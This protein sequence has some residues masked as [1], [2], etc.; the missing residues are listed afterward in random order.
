MLLFITRK[1]GFRTLIDK[2]S[3]VDFPPNG[4]EVHYINKTGKIATN[5]FVQLFDPEDTNPVVR[6]TV[7]S[8]GVELYTVRGAGLENA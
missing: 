6:I 3:G 1:N 7:Y 8:G 5:H 4:N 2:V